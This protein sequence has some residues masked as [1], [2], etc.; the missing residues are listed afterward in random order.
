MLHAATTAPLDGWSVALLT[1][2]CIILPALAYRT[3]RIFASGPLPVP[4]T[5]FYAETIAFQLVVLA[6]AGVCAWR[7]DIHVARL[8]E[9]WL[10]GAASAAALLGVALL[11]LKVRWPG[12]PDEMKSRLY[13]LLP[14]SPEEMRLFL[15][16]CAV[17]SLSEEIVYRGVTVA[18]LG[19]L[20]GHSAVAVGIAAVVFALGH[21]VQGWR[22][23]GVIF[24]FALAFHAIVYV[25][26]S[27]LFAIVAHFAYDVAA[28]VLVPQWMAQERDEDVNSA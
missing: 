22:S 25:A 9:R 28:G 8:P 23:V 26:G 24:V 17:A 16:L 13:E 1:I 3:S 5:W 7:N 21:M 18:L 20:T 11:L 27:L 2:V 15:P 6:V 4:R 14:H 10:S 12:R 19:R